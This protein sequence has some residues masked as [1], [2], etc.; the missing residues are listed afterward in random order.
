MIHLLPVPRGVAFDKRYQQLAVLLRYYK[1]VKARP[2]SFV[3]LIHL[4]YAV[5]VQV[6]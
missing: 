1:L 4:A 2:S 5:Q 3:T 6:N